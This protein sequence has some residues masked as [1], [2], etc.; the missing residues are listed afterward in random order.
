MTRSPSWQAI[1]Y[2]IIFASKG[3]TDINAYSLAGKKNVIRQLAV[4]LGDEDYYSSDAESEGEGSKGEGSDSE[5]E[6]SDSEGSESAGSDSEG[7]SS[8]GGGD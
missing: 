3:R 1:K 4:I 6:G 8:K 5:R 7:E 2:S